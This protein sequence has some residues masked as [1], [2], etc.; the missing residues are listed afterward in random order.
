VIIVDESKLSEQLGEKRT[1]PVEVVTFGH[2]T[3]AG[4]LERF[5]KA[6][7]RASGA[8][9]FVTDSGNYIYDLETGPIAQPAALER[10][11]HEL[12][13]VVES[14]LFCARADLVIVAGSAGVRKL[15]RPAE[16]A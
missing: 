7:L 9:P 8:K 6:V 15:E 3:T 14:G 4:L 5:G 13:G 10:E 2:R 11:L 1:V 12:P 16:L